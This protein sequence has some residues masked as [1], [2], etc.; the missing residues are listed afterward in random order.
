[1]MLHDG[2]TLAKVELTWYMYDVVDMY[3]VANGGS[4]VKVVL[5]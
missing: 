1:M 2:G 5:T 4:L 3:D